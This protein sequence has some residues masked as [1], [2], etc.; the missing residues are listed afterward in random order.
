MEKK[1]GRG[2]LGRQLTMG[3]ERERERAKEGDKV[4]ES[5]L[6][7]LPTTSPSSQFCLSMT[8][9]VSHSFIGS[10]KHLEHL[11]SESGV[12]FSMECPHSATEHT[13]G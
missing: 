13:V 12:S 10:W 6:L 2:D 4:S 11:S 8:A 9:I 5:I 7:T 3:R 1:E